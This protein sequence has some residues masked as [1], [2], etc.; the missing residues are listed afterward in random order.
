MDSKKIKILAIDDNFDN[1]ITIQALILESFH[2]A[3]VQLALSGMEGLAIAETFLPDVILLDII[4]PEM[5]GYEVCEKIKA[6]PMLCN[7]PVVFV[8]ALKGDKESRIKA[9]EVGADAFLAKPIELTELIAQIRAMVKIKAANELKLDENKRLLALVEERT[10]EL[11]MT[12]LAT[13]NLL[14]D[15]KN[16]NQTR[17]NTEEALRASEALYKSILEASPDNITVTDLE[18]NIQI[19]SPIGLNLIGYKNDELIIGRNI[20]EFLVPEDIGRAMQNLQGMFNGVFNGP[21][22]YKIISL[23]KQ[24]IEVEINAE[25]VRDTDG[26]PTQFVFA[27]RDITERKEA[28]KALRESEEKY[29]LITEKISDVVWLM[30]LKGKSLFVSQSIEKFTGFTVEEY[31][32]QSISDRFTPESAAVGIKMLNDEVKNFNLENLKT[33]EFK[34]TLILDYKCKNGSVKTG[35]LL[36]TPYYDEQDKLIGIHGVTRDITDRKNSEKALLESELK[37]RTLVENSPNGIAIYQQ[38]KFVYVNKTGLEIFGTSE[39]NSLIGKPVLSIVHPDSLEQ[40]IKRMTEVSQ[41]KQVPPLEEKLVRSDG[42]VFYAEVTALGT[43]FNGEPAGQV[44]VNDITERKMIAEEL[45]ESED[46]YYKFVNNNDDLIFIKDDQF[47]F[48]MINDAVAQF[49]GKTREEIIGKTD[50]ELN[51]EESNAFCRSSDI[52]SLQS[53]K[54]IIIEEVLKG[55]TYETT[56]FPISLKGN[57]KGIGGILHDITDRKEAEDRLMYVARLYA[58]LSQIN[59]TIVSAKNETEL[60]DSI[61]RSAIDFGKF[62]MGW[63]GIYNEEKKQIIPHSFAGVD[64]GYLNILK[65]DP[66]DPIHGNGPTGRA[67]REQKLIFCNDV[68]NDPMMATWKTDAL[69]RGYCSSFASPILRNGKIFG[70]FTL[71][72]S[73][74]N[75]FDEEEQKLLHEITQNISFAIDSFENA[76]EKQEAETLLKESEE[77]YRNLMENSPEGITIYVDGKIVYINKEAV[78]LM[79]GVDKTELLGKSIIE[80]IHPENQEL[81][82]ERMKLVAT[83]PIN[84]IFPSVEEKYIRLD[85]TEVSVEIKVMPILYEGNPAIQL[86]GH[87]ITDRNEAELALEQSRME[88]MAIYDNAP[89]MMCVI[90]ENRKIIFANQSFTVFSNKSLPDVLDGHACGIFNCINSFDHP[91]G[92]GF[93]ANCVKCSL[94]LALEGTMRTGKGYKNVEYQTVLIHDEKKSNVSLL[95]STALLDSQNSKRILLCLIDITERKMTEEALQK[96]ETLLRTFIDN[97][98]FEIWAR[99]NN[100]VGILENKK[101]TEHFGS[102]I[103]ITPETDTRVSNEIKDLWIRNNK[104]V[105]DGEI[106]NE[107]IEFDVLGESRIFQQICFP[108]IS[109][110]KTMGIAGFNIDITDRKMAEQKILESNMRFEMAAKI[111]NLAWWEMN[112]HTKKVL[113]GSNK[114]DMLGFDAQNFTSYEHFVQLIHPDDVEKCNALMLDHL[115][116]KTEKYEVEFRMRTASGNYKWIYDVGS[117]SKRNAE[118]KA[119]KVSGLTLDITDRKISL[120]ALHESQ[121][122][123]IKFAAHLQNIREEERSNLARDIHD[124]LGQILIAMKIDL[125]LLK[126]VALNNIQTTKYNDIKMKFED[127][128]ILVDNTLKSARRI[129]TDLRPEVLDLLGLIETVKQHLKNFEERHKVSCQFIN[130]TTTLQL[131]SQQ[132]VALYRIVQEALNNISKHAKASVVKVVLDQK[133]ENISL[134]ISDNG[135]GF[136]MKD[137]KKTDSYG[138]LG[139]KERVVLLNGE[140]EILSK[141]GNGTSIQVWFKTNQQNDSAN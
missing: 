136:D 84:T 104:R 41:G 5:D 48:I 12:H 32:K 111:G 16:E 103:G 85:G 73:E 22:E 125:G 7:I 75:F 13:L 62:R 122:Q 69:N 141:P 81:I 128:S 98:P 17:I 54:P 47:R 140:L 11:K 63:I 90:D 121:E 129:M 118:G 6:N 76:K 38:G 50:D 19:I 80:F 100:N 138:L 53:D 109:E 114:I 57:S 135:Q 95:A 34:E 1:L 139:I 45:I 40:V 58:F 78:R 8:T 92:C 21:E 60:F 72:A 93:G 15:L 44:I 82:I 52:T 119:L 20:T 70:T 116:G 51:D 94:R 26:N 28:Q 24:I 18:G 89:V 14:E 120:Q 83:A 134:Q 10:N 33:K 124:D 67:F 113:Y 64:N 117:V 42:S 137:K 115:L 61:C 74:I 91:L 127:L 56:K 46:R 133:N 123:L 4:M 132:S 96:S 23:E 131:N 130:N 126:Q 30:D 43:T 39:Q 88:L 99:D 79:R 66:F 2:Q 9:L 112:L 49:F 107:E 65:I 101:L 29:R 37:Y 102:I 68:A 31:L 27:I 36:I 108:I 55:R 86:S 87:D 71:Y 3:N 106:L 59:K 25:F 97:S 105:F 110:S 77:K 35:E